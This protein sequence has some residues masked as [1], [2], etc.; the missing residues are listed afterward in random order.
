MK[1]LVTFLFTILFAIVGYSQTYF[2]GYS[3]PSSYSGAYNSG[4]GLQKTTTTWNDGVANSTETVGNGEAA[5]FDPDNNQD[6]VN[7]GLVSTRSNTSLNAVYG[8]AQGNN[9]GSTTYL[10]A[11]ENGV[12]VG[13]PYTGSY[14]LFRINYSNGSILYQYTTDGTN[15]ITFYTSTK[16]PSGTYYAAVQIYGN[17]AVYQWYK[18]GSTIV[19][20]VNTVT[21]PVNVT[22]P[23]ATSVILTASST[24]SSGTITGVSWTQVSG[25]NSASLSGNTTN[26]LT[27][28][29]LI[30]G[31][32]VFR[33]TST[34]SLSNS[35]FSDV[36][37]NVAQV[38]TTP[39]ASTQG[40]VTV[41][42]PATSVALR[43][44][45]STPSGTIT[46]RSWTFVSGPNTPTITNAAV[47]TT[48]ATGLI[49]G[50]YV[51]KY[52][53]TNSYGNTVTANL[54]VSVIVASTS[55]NFSFVQIASTTDVP[56]PGRALEQWTNDQWAIDYPTTGSSQTGNC[57]ENY[58]RFK[59]YEIQNDDSSFTW[60]FFD[61]KLNA[62]IAA[63][64]KFNLAVMPLSQGDTKTV[65][66]GYGLSYPLFLH[67]QMQAEANPDW[68]PT[69]MGQWVPNWNSPSYLRA[70]GKLQKAIADHINSG[71]Y[72]GVPY[73]N[74]IGI[75][76]IRGFGNFGEWH[77]YPWTSEITSAY[78]PT[79]A[80]IKSI[81]DTNLIYFPNYI[82]VIQ[83]ESFG[84]PN[85]GNAQP[86]LQGQYYALT[87]S[88]N[89]GVIGWRRDSWGWAGTW[90]PGFLES[91][92]GTYSGQSFSTLIMNK[93]KVA[94]ITGE[95]MQCCTQDNGFTGNY[96]GDIVRE[97]NLYHLSKIGNGNLEA[98]TSTPT[99]TNMQA[100]GHVSGYRLVLTGGSVT[101]L[102]P[103]TA[104]TINLGWQNI[105]LTP[106]Y[107][108]WFVNYELRN[109]SGA[110]VWTG[111]S[112][113]RPRLFL[114]S[115]TSTT[116][117]DT[118]TLPS[119]IPSGAYGL[120]VKVVDSLSY[121]DPLPLAITGRTS[122]GAYL[123]QNVTV[124]SGG[125]P[126]PV[127]PPVANAGANQTLTP[128]NNTSTTLTGSGTSS[129]GTIVGYAWS[130]ISGTTA[131][132]STP[133]SATTAVTG[134]TPGT[135]NQF[136]LIV[137]DNL[138]DTGSAV[139]Q[140][141]STSGTTALYISTITSA[142]NTT[143][144]PARK[145]VIIKWTDNSTDRI[146]LSSGGGYITGIKQAYAIID[147]VR[148]LTVTIRFSDN[149]TQ[150]FAKKVI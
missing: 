33:Y 107:Y 30:V 26:T 54:T 92:P 93:W 119:G 21:T 101:A 3:L 13:S 116:V 50:T 142:W 63:K 40:A 83:H 43:G 32:Y 70:W 78:Q 65:A 82:N 121:M 5:T 125:T 95:P 97:A 134:I 90:F 55:S 9:G 109:S 59:W 103:S 111:Q 60:T 17:H 74:I 69:S 53:V 112:T 29:G 47:D 104:F 12:N 146:E 102:S 35:T 8:V 139:V 120:Y 76:D 85:D 131:V 128:P 127:V 136:K 86:N 99:I 126:P 57:F 46:S 24:T 68:V 117:T 88:N 64:R 106:V 37:V 135:V 100:V 148:H 66:G 96:Y 140:V 28:S 25:P 137:T 91:N 41:V 72:N 2:T 20:P 36:T 123:L 110:V 19:A 62:A 61:S 143:V 98:I 34:N 67:T 7:Y 14:S 23:T 75:V 42:A 11:T 105:G 18:T 52:S 118:Y 79:Y 16:V 122:D 150:Y 141:T 81:I 138:G 129:T 94:P 115:T 133:N 87:A 89:K 144:S 71:S 73:K 48:T 147:G 132:I 4:H 58:Y 51:F 15:W 10:Q 45:A 1:K 77:T 27:A 114:P 22:Y 130:Q 80:T 108:D 145:Y 6:Y 44:Y 39:T 84:G 56:G 31:V 124:G 113:F 38:S 149:T 49:T